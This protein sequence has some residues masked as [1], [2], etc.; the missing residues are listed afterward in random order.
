MLPFAN[1]TGYFGAVGKDKIGTQLKESAT[2]DGVNANF[3]E[4]PE[5]PTGKCAVLVNGKERSLV[6]HISAAEKFLPS[7]LATESAQAMIEK[8]QFFYIASFF[9]T[10]SVD[11]LRVVADHAVANGK[12]FC[13]KPFALIT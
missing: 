10:V 5:T 1:A 11:S 6:A 3:M 4:C 9:L 12:T 7:H 13:I 8:A 2:K